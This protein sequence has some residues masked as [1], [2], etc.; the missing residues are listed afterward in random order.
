MFMD[1]CAAWAG[2]HRDD[3]FWRKHE[4][5]CRAYNY[6]QNVEIELND[7]LKMSL[8]WILYDRA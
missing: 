4:P 8:S 2:L 5:A 7:R 1:G 3:S 6:G